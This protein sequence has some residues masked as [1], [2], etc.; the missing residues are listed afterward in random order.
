MS[1][2]ES[3]NYPRPDN[4]RLEDN[5]KPLRFQIVDFFVPENDRSRREL[6]RI[7]FCWYFNPSAR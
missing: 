4:I 6:N 5:N 2:V 7:H 1:D 3:F